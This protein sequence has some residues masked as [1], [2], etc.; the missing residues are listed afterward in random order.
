LTGI[1]DDTMRTYYVM[2]SVEVAKW[3]KNNIDYAM[4]ILS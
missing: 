2:A 4:G 1:D 3:K